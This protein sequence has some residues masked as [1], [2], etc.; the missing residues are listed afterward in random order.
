[1]EMIHAFE[2]SLEELVEEP[3]TTNTGT[4]KEAHKNT[5]TTASSTIGRRWIWVHHITNR[6]RIKAI[7]SE[8]RERQLGGYVKSGYPGIVLVEGYHCDDFVKFIKGSKSCPNGFGRN[9]GHHVRGQVDGLNERKLPET[10]VELTEMSQ[11]ASHCRE[12]GLE[13]EFL[14]Y[15]MQHK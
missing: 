2:T 10:C 12:Y 3:P 4:K 1:M 15:A 5:A 14:E 7:L 11:L 13:D 9:W 6:E 8:A